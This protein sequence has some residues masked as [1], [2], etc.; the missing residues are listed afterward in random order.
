MLRFYHER[1]HAIVFFNIP[2]IPHHSPYG[3]CKCNKYTL[4]LTYASFV[5]LIIGANLLV[6][7]GIMK[8]KRNKLSLSQILFWILLLAVSYSVCS[9]YLQK[10]TLNGN[11]IIQHCA[12]PVLISLWYQSIVKWTLCVIGF[13]QDLWQKHSWCPSSF[14]WFLF[15]YAGFILYPA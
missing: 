4:D 12:Y 5:P 1:N 8:T 9:S 6:I 7:F 13:T 11:Q 10:F 2:Q 3:R 15:L 14:W